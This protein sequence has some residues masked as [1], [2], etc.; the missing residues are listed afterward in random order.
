VIDHIPPTLT[1]PNSVSIGITNLFTEKQVNDVK[2]IAQAS[3]RSE[4]SQGSGVSFMQLAFRCKP[5]VPEVPAKEANQ[6]DYTALYQTSQYPLTHYSTG[7][8]FVFRIVDSKAAHAPDNVDEVRDELIADMRLLKGFE[9]AKAAATTLVTAHTS[10]ETLKDAYDKDTDLL[11][12]K[13]TESDF[14]YFDAQPFS[15]VPQGQAAHGRMPNGMFIPNGV[16]V[17]PNSV[18][19]DLF[20]MKSNDVKSFDLPD[21]ATV[22]VAEFKEVQLAKQDEF[23]K[24]KKDLR[25]QLVYER[26]SAAIKDWLDPEKIRARTGF[27]L[28]TR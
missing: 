28:I 25:S 8:V 10:G 22:M 13:G 21:R 27:A 23:D 2:P 9:A 18:V 20:A 11:S 17:V 19:D 1:F 26:R 14:G 5:A 4:H 6:G 7:D 15:R 12:H 16:G 3:F 24:L